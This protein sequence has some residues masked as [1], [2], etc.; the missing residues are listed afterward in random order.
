MP[1]GT[2]ERTPPPFFRQ[3]PSALTK[4]VCCSALAVFLMAADTR[5]A[6]IEPLRAGVATV[7]HPVERVLLVPVRL[8]QGAVLYMAG[9]REAVIAEEHARSL[10]ARQ[11]EQ[12]ARAEVLDQENRHLRELLGLRS[13]LTARAQA[14]EVLY[15]ARDPFSRKLVLDRGQAHGV[16]AGSP[17]INEAGVLGQV[18]R[19]YPLSS[20]VTLLTDKDAAIPLLNTRTQQR[21]VAYGANA[22]AG[23]ELR[24]M[25]D[26]VDIVEGDLMNTSGIDG[27]YPP[28]LPVARVVSVERRA[29]GGFA[30]IGLAPLTQ[31]DGVRHVLVLEPIGLQR[32]E[33]A[34]PEPEAAA[35]P[36]HASA[37]QGAAS[38]AASAP[39]GQ[40][41]RALPAA[42]GAAAAAAAAVRPGTPAAPAVATGTTTP[43]P[44]PRPA[45]ARPA[46]APAAARSTAPAA[47][48]ARTPGAQAPAAASRPPPAAAGTASAPRPRAATAPSPAAPR[49][50]TAP[51]PPPARAT[52]APTPQRT[53]PAPAPR[54]ANAPAAPAPAPSRP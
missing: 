37:P 10:L 1:L 29:E 28:G 34:A 12:A 51:A 27:V 49:A 14:A 40:A 54:P 15:E 50:T 31:A 24:F 17:V 8:V 30:R 23:M 9:L 2:L 16:A 39:A 13:R 47:P 52:A 3:G 42:A 22:G 43:A 53:A 5:L 36:A 25:P 11:S 6:L 26:N 45:E 44:R 20:E 18:T 7:L 41:P 32:P 19:V 46:A 33:A 35:P 4:L 38:P 21:G 48:A